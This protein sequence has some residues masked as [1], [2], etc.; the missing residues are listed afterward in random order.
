L[1]LGELEQAQ[2]ERARLLARTVEIAEHE[3][4]RVAGDLHDGP[5]QQLTAVAFNLDR[6]ALTAA[7]VRAEAVEALA[8][9]IRIEVADVMTDLRRLMIELR[10]PVLDE[11]GLEAALRDSA[12]E[13][14][15]STVTHRVRSTI[16]GFDAAPEVETVVYR[17]AREALSNVRKHAEATQVEVALEARAGTLSLTIE[18]DGLR[19]EVEEVDGGT[20]GMHLGLIGMR[21]RVESVGGEL[22]VSSSFA[23][24]RIEAR[25]PLRPRVEAPVLCCIALRR[26]AAAYLSALCRPVLEVVRTGAEIRRLVVGVEERTRA[27]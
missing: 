3:R 6:L 26:P 14:L 18:D 17:V 11:R 9:D 8:A 5:I 27:Q 10:P 15:E 4:M 25:L 2:H 22:L 19:F 12:G 24:K 7:G 23:G 13:I 1:T 20:R 21:E 16:D